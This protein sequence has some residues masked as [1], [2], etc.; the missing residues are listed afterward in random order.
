MLILFI[1]FSLLG[2]LMWNE[3][4]GLFST[5]AKSPSTSINSSV[6]QENILLVHIDDLTSD[7]PRLVSVWAVFFTPSNPP[8]LTMRELYPDLY[9][10][11][12]VDEIK[13]L[14]SINSNGELDSKFIKKMDM[15]QIQW[16]GIMLVDHQAIAAFDDWLDIKN[17]PQSV[18][19]AIDI[20]GALIQADD[21]LDW[22][23]MVC[24]QIQTL[25]LQDLPHMSW[26]E[27]IP[28]HMHS[29]LYFDELITIWD[30]LASSEIPPHCETLAP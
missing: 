18:Q 12:N 10:D 20:P 3:V 28:K 11:Q 19:Q 30:T 13:S 24:K 6:Q 17:P 1:G 5:T 16:T 29:D 9:D 4:K 7:D 22:F 25:D 26:T 23:G 27:I 8:T 14:F 15:Y 2:F 21:E